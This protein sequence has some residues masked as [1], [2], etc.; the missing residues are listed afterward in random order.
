MSWCVNALFWQSA[1]P[2]PLARRQP[3]EGG[4]LSVGLCGPWTETS[5]KACSESVLSML[6]L[7]DVTEQITFWLTRSLQLIPSDCDTAEISL[8]V[9]GTAAVL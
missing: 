5:S 9:L 3:W 8:V 7:Y 2:Q 1:G 6:H 4:R